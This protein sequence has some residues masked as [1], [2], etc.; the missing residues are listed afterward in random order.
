VQVIN[1]VLS[2][3]ILEYPTI[4]LQVHVAVSQ[5][6]RFIMNLFQFATQ[7]ATPFRQHILL[8]TTFVDGVSILFVQGH[9]RSLESA[10]TIAA[11]QSVPAVAPEVIP[12]ITQALK[13]MGFA[14]FHMGRHAKVLRGL[15][16]FAHDL[17]SLPIFTCL[18]EAKFYDPML[19]L[20]TALFHFLCNI[21]ALSGDEG[22]GED[23]DELVPEV[24]SA[25]LRAALASFLES[26]VAPY[27]INYVEHWHQKFY[28]LDTDA[29]VSQDLATFQEIDGIFYELKSK[30]APPPPVQAVVTQAPAAKAAAESKMSKHLADMPSLRAQKQAAPNKPAEDIKQNFVMP[31]KQVPHNS[32]ASRFNCALNGHVMKNPVTSKYG[33]TF[34]K[35]TIEQWLRQ[36]GSVCPITGQY[37]TIDDLKPNK[38]LQAEIMAAVIRESLQG[39]NQEDEVDLY[40]F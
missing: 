5:A 20:Y 23:Y 39:R 28:A 24:R 31:K 9:V 6:M 38:E 35:D 11:T 36:Q 15:C 10:L 18:R 13:F 12:G 34:E 7:G 2:P 29:L 40:D 1:D 33:H 16:S 4:S 21:D 32:G 27:G 3:Q 30:A 22:L 8:S 37:L 17:L 26:Q 19:A 25:K 14:T